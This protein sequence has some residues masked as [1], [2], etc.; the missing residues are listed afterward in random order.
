MNPNHAL[1]P[2]WMFRWVNRDAAAAPSSVMSTRTEVQPPQLWSADP[3]WRV[4][5]ARWFTTAA[6]WLPAQSRP[7]N[8]LASVKDEFLSA[9]TDLSGTA[10]E[11]LCERIARA[12][13]LRELW[14]LRAPVYGLLATA[15]NQ[16][17]AERRMNR[18]NRHF[19]VRTPRP[20][21]PTLH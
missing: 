18:L 8:R 20:G 1:L 2:E 7:V 12:R 3:G 4:R 15:M 17:E 5:L 6:P 11:V 9:M 10:A 19:P 21:S 13:S 16:S 14:H